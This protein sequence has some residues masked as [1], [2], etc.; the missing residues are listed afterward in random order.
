MPATKHLFESSS[1][2]KLLKLFSKDELKEFEKFVHSPYHNNRSEVTRFFDE[3]KKFYPGFKRKDFTKEK[4]FTRIY[5]G[6]KYKDDVIRRLS[7]NLFKLG[8]EFA[9]IENFSKDEY[10]FEKNLLDYFFSKN[11]DKFFLRHNDKIQ[12][13]LRDLK[14]RDSEYYH[15]Q[16]AINEIHRSYMLKSDPTYKKS[17]Y[18]KQIEYH[19]KYVL[20]SLLRLYGFAEYETYFFNKKYDLKFKDDLLRISQNAN[21]FDS[22]TVE[23]YYLLLKLYDRNNNDEAFY[24]LKKLIEENSGHFNKEE[25]FNFYIHL[26]NYCNIAKLNHDR[27]YNKAE[28]ELALKMVEGGLLIH[29]GVIDP[30]WFRGIFYKCFNAGEFEYAGNF[31]EKYKS[32]VSGKDNMNVVNHVYAQIAIHKRDYDAALKYLESASYQHLNDKWAI[33]NMYLKIY[34][35]T[36]E[37]KQFF[38]CA[39][40]IKHLI[41]E[42]GSWNENLILPI[43]N[44]INISTR[45]FKKKLGELKISANELKQEILRSKVIGRKWLIEK[46][47]E[48]GADV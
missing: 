48:L 8:E 44:F 19:W 2:I 15:R 30:G 7:S 39:D 12:K 21:F 34:Y 4:I 16:S 43:R 46:A 3:I 13:N 17:G 9:A 36:N 11:D 23:I 47:E 25:C 42:E 24:R 26:F 10:N 1:L 33:K 28:F 22:K 29:N 35:E 41:R 40:S 5:P 14:I 31:I 27:D 45:L 6:K 20:T 18:E 32:I 38:Y 37:Y